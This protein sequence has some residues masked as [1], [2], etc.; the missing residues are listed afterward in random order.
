MSILPP[1]TYDQ[2]VFLDGPALGKI[3]TS[4]GQ[5][6]D[7][8]YNGDPGS[9]WTPNFVNLTV[10]GTP[11]ITGR[12]Y[13]QGRLYYFSVRIV[14]ST[15]TTATAGTTYI[16]NLPVRITADG[17]C[18]VV[19][20]NLGDTANGICVSASNRIYPPSWSA[21]TVPLTICGWVESN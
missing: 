3:T 18:N 10:S 15:S 11:I 20:G 2:L 6:F 17:S 9:S 14:P 19:A 12:Y 1:P 13:K 5:Y 4:W 21:V 7:Q 8:F 16:D